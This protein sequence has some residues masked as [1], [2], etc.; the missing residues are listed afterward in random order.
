MLRALTTSQTHVVLHVAHNHDYLCVSHMAF[1]GLLQRATADSAVTLVC[2]CASF[3]VASPCGWYA[4]T[5][6]A[7]LLVWYVRT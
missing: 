1:G 3:Y 6:Q 2:I 7:H 5:C 4:L